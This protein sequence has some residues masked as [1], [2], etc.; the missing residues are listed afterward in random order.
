MMLFA[1]GALAMA[2]ALMRVGSI[3]VVTQ[4]SASM[5]I[6]QTPTGVCRIV[7]ANVLRRAVSDP[8]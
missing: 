6:D 8:A 2:D 1:R 5:A 7:E 4:H 3:Q